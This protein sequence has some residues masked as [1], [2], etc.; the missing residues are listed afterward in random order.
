MRVWKDADRRP[1]GK[2]AYSAKRARHERAQNATR[3]RLERAKKRPERF[4]RSIVCLH[5]PQRPQRPPE[6]QRGPQEK[7]DKKKVYPRVN[8]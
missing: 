7:T 4:S 5:R 2:H 3:T 8:Y 6:P 1:S